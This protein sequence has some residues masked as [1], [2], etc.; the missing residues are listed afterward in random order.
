VNTDSLLFWLIAVTLLAVLA[1]GAWQFMSVQRSRHRRGEHGHVSH[2][3]GERD[4]QAR[5]PEP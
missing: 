2:P 4:P 5:S 1:Y 3:P